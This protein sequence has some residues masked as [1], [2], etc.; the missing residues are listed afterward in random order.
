MQ[1]IIDYYLSPSSPWTYLGSGP[2]TKIAQAAGAKVNVYAVGY[3]KIFPASGGLPLPKRAPQR[4]AYRMMELKRWAAYLNSPIIFEPKNFPSTAPISSQVI[5][6]VRLN[7]DDALMLSNAILAALWED[8]RNIDDP[9]V[10]TQIC[11]ACGLDGRALTAQAETDLVNA[12]MEAD[13]EQAL[14]AGVFGAPSYVID[15]EIF[16][17]QDRVD[18]VARKLAVTL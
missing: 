4:I 11:D 14:A 17:G 9:A 6:A 3:H 1:P 7:G 2:L 5:T 12:Q 10:V 18:F 8:D 13:T 16:W 15:G